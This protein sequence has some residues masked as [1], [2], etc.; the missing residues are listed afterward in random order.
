[1]T[2]KWQKQIPATQRKKEKAKRKGQ[3]PMSQ[4]LSVAISL[5]TML[6]S[7]YFAGAGIFSGT[8]SFLEEMVASLSR[9]LT[10][11]DSVYLMRRTLWRV[12]QIAAP[13]LAI[14]VTG[15]FVVGVYQTGGISFSMERM[16]F[17][18]AKLNPA[19]GFNKIFSKQGLMKLL[20]SL[21]KVAAIALVLWV[22]IEPRIPEILTL[23]QQP[24]GEVLRYMLY[25][26][27]LVV[28][29]TVIALF[30]IALLD[31]RYQAWRHSEEL[32]MTKEEHKEEMKSVEGNPKV[33]RRILEMQ[34]QILLEQMYGDVETADVVVTNPTHI[35]VALKYTPGQPGAPKVVAK[36][37]NRIAERIRE[38]ARGKDIPIIENK[39]LARSLYALAT[40][41]LEIPEKLY[42]PVA[43]L[44]AYVYRLREKRAANRKR[45]Q[46]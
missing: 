43:E 27:S 15:A 29:R 37:V 8:A 17:D 6:V 7:M 20:T 31:R 34:R 40:V 11:A 42:R 44:L 28:I 26:T 35:A 19:K 32:K 41:G 45:N 10:E 4:E 3:F 21:G 14:Y 38:I 25:I 39:P 33:K 46:R 24:L 1:M 9:P 13:I 5:A 12:L 16:R 18:I 22:T 30:V 23:A 36:G 2:E